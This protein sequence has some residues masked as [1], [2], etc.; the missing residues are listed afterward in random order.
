MK[1]IFM[2]TTGWYDT[3]IGNTICTAIVN[4]TDLIMLDAGY[5][6]R[7]A[8]ELTAGRRTSL[9]LSHFH[10]DHIAGLHT[11]ARLRV[12]GG[13]NIYGQPGTAKALGTIVNEPFTI[14]L[15]KLPYP[16]KVQELQE[17][18][19]EVPFKVECRW[20]KHSSPC[21]GYR[22][23]LG[24][25]VAYI[26]DTGFCESAIELARG[27]DLVIT[28][29]S[30]P[31]GARSEGWPH[32]NPGDGARIAAEAGAE[33]LI[34]THFDASNYTSFGQRRNAERAARKIFMNTTAAHDG[35]AIEV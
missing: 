19:H 11:L 28:E 3:P 1:I 22:F 14:P 5:G 17:G 35:M 2:G 13:L 6:I 32:L 23:E 15:D 27:A 20:L 18:R 4:G 24:R 21:Y 10:I 26:T 33:R 12:E 9:F 25:T 16:V 34:L 31:V 8:V 29:C 7:R 30:L